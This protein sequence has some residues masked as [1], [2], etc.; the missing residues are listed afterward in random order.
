MV[1]QD[2]A[3]M[4][5]YKITGAKCGQATLDGKYASAAK[6][7]AGLSED[8]CSKHGYTVPAGDQFQS[9]PVIA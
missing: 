4:T 2:E 5:L 3:G 9:V 6:S 1:S 8:V 7:F